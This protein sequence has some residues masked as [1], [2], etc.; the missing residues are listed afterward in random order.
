[1]EIDLRGVAIGKEEAEQW[2]ALPKSVREDLERQVELCVNLV[3][4]MDGS[5]KLYETKIQSDLI[6]EHGGTIDVIVLEGENLHVVDFKFGRVKVDIEDNKQIQCYLNLARQL[7]PEAKRFFGSIIQPIYSDRMQTVEFSEKQLNAHMSAVLEASISDHFK[8]GDHCQ[9]CP[10]GPQCQ[11]LADYLHSQIQDFPD[12]TT[13]VGEVTDKPTA[14]Q[15]AQLAR[16]YKTFKLAEKATEG[17]GEILK[18]WAREGA[19][20]KAHGLGL[21][22]TNR[23]C[24][25]VDA[26][27]KLAGKFQNIDFTARKLMTPKQVQEVLG[28]SKVKFEEEFKDLLETKSVTSLVVGKDSNELPEFD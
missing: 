22:V 14:D 6:G 5:V 8:A 20:V 3:D 13:F 28:L 15:V 9:W 12:L 27:A 18:R 19:D 21:R 24:W 4:D 23:V 16:I 2:N 1:V 11:V 7:F 10:A 26:E 17:A 25:V